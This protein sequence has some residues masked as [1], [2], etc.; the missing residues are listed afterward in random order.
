MFGGSTGFVG[1]GYFLEEGLDHWRFGPCFKLVT[2]HCLKIVTIKAK[3]CHAGGM[4]FAPPQ[5]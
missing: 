3:A 2:Q 5:T 1:A 4:L